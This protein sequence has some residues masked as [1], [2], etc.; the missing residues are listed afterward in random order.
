MN[1]SKSD[2]KPL[3]PKPLDHRCDSFNK[4]SYWS[5]KYEDVRLDPFEI[6]TLILL[7][8]TISSQILLGPYNYMTELPGK[9]V[10]SKLIQAFNTIL[11]VPQPHLDTISEI[12]GMLHTASLLVDDVEDSSTLRRGFPVAHS[13][14]GTAQTINSS[15]YIYFLALQKV[16]LLQSTS[17][18]NTFTE[19]LVN[20]HRGQGLD[21]YW[22]DTLTC[23]TEEEYLDM[24]M[25][26][27]LF[28][29]L[30]PYH[31]SVNLN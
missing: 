15:N 24:V 5:K 29:I 7:S 30:I 21:L 2:D 11:Q 25:N 16:V 28:F 1:Q 13:I 6:I 22:R 20:L 12:V 23:P 18:I 19:E 4:G 31:V 9:G 17:A 27:M 3:D 10:R 14:F 8:L 26:S